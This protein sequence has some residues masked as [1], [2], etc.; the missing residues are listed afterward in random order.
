MKNMGDDL[1]KLDGVDGK[2]F[3]P[4]SEWAAVEERLGF[5]LPRNYKRLVQLFGASVWGN[6]NDGQVRVLSPFEEET[7]KN[8]FS[9]GDKILEGYR[10]VYRNELASIPF[11]F[12][13]EIGGLLLWSEIETASVFFLI[14]G[15]PESYPIV[16]LDGSSRFD[17]HLLLRPQ[18]VVYRLASRT[19][20]SSIVTPRRRQDQ[21][22]VHRYA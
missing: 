17:V 11:S 20:S 14:K 16:I 15:E 10:Q 9:Y 5:A 7:E 6:A 2:D 19:L 12:E 3:Q 1:S 13:R 8:L 18:D 4:S 22:A 21:G